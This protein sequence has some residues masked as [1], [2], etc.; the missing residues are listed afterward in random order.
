MGPAGMGIVEV[1]VIGLA[2]LAGPGSFLPISLPPRPYD[3]EMAALAPQECFYFYMQMGRA[4]Q[5][6][7]AR[8]ATER[9]LADP[10]VRKSID[11]SV[12]AVRQWILSAAA[13]GGANQE[14]RQ[15]LARILRAI[16]DTSQRPLLLFFHIDFSFEMFRG[17]PLSPTAALVVR[18]GPERAVEID[19]LLKEVLES[20][21]IPLVERNM[22]DGVSANRI[23]LPGNVLVDIARTDGLLIV[24]LGGSTLDDMLARRGGKEPSWLSRLRKELQVERPS[25]VSSFQV[26]YPFDFAKKMGAGANLEALGLGNLQAIE[27]V[28]GIDGDRFVSRQRLRFEGP[29]TGLLAQLGTRPVTSDDFTSIPSDALAAVVLR[30]QPAQLLEHFVNAIT[31]QPILGRG[32]L[33]SEFY[34]EIEDELGFHL[35]ND[36]M[37]AL[38]GDAQLVLFAASPP[39]VPDVR[40]TLGVGDLG[41]AKRVLKL[42]GENI[43][44]R[45]ADDEDGPMQFVSS[46]HGGAEIVGLVSKNPQP[47]NSGSWNAV[48]ACIAHKRVVFSNSKQRLEQFIDRPASSPHLGERPRIRELLGKKPFVVAY[49]DTPV[50]LRSARAPIGQLL[51]LWLAQSRSDTAQP[52]DHP[53]FPVDRV[54]AHVQPDLFA[55]YQH[56][57]A[58]IV[59]G[60][61][62]VPGLSLAAMAGALSK[63]LLPA[64]GQARAVSQRAR[65]A[66][67]LRN[68]LLAAHLFDADR[69]AFPAAYSVDEQ[70]K[71]LLSWRVQLLPYLEEQELYNQFHLDEPWDSEHNKKL[72]DQMPDVFASP[73]MEQADGK[74]TYLAIRL[75]DAVF[76]APEGKA[77]LERARKGVGTPLEDITDGTSNT[78]V[79][80]EVAPKDAVIWTKPDD[81][82]IAPKDVPGSLSTPYRDK[83]LAGFADGSVRM[84]RLG[85]DGE[86]WLALFRKS[87]G[88]VIPE[89]STR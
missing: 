84:L 72:I 57:E 68:L 12:T 67:S 76:A 46:R 6:T 49:V 1:I 2:S 63:V 88:K 41:K 7:A 11:S 16:E 51:S 39:A 86:T 5:E 53:Q 45:V 36:L 59:E 65:S 20:E 22:A 24:A 50:A 34:S 75:P 82:K 30:T 89:E 9:L 83:I 15:R 61:Q 47:D 52:A 55:A 66:N 28:A 60:G 73:H 17:Q 29:I 13:K 14:G 8:S 18:F 4:Q 42:L 74:T 3:A 56:P 25:A 43:R 35:K 31:A 23:A 19:A 71:P 58:L 87:D 37:P 10:A 38:A 62:T 81:L 77:A 44:E 27:S 70:G 85:L 54:L 32:D 33:E 69:Q 78:V 40:V 79:L 48:Y 64:V 26:H 21:G 80:L